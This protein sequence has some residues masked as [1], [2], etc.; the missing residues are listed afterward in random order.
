M[1]FSNDLK[2]F[3]KII[4]KNNSVSEMNVYYVK[5]AT[6]CIIYLYTNS[7]SQINLFYLIHYLSQSSQF[8]DITTWIVIIKLIV[9]VLSFI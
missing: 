3:K 1:L 5:W 4:F 6:L 7:I 2:L 8:T 9:I